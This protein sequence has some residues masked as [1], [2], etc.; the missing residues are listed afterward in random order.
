MIKWLCGVTVI[1]VTK[2][3]NG[4]YEVDFNNDRI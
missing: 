1:H 3:D 2:I 4:N